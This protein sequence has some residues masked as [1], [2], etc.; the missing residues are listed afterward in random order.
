VKR[1]LF[2]REYVYISN[3]TK[4][5]SNDPIEFAQLMEHQGAGEIIIQ[6]IKNDG[7]MQGYDVQLVK[8]ISKAVSIP[9]VA[10]GGA[11][12]LDHLKEVFVNG[13]ANGLAA[14]SLFVY[15]G[16]RNAVLI[17]YLT[18]RELLSFN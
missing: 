15:H 7:M 12:N 14:G 8:R 16:S 5:T 4:S 2:G 10:L 3:G 18:K 6:S 1:N 11:G 17:N 9:V 13:Y